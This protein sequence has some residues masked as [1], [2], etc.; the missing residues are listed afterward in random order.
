MEK[1]FLEKWIS[2][3]FDSM[4]MDFSKQRYNNMEEL[5]KYMYGSA[6]VIGYMLCK[7]FDVEE[8]AY[9][10][11]EHLANAMQIGN[12][13]RDIGVDYKLGRTY[14]PQ[15]ILDKYD[16]KEIKKEIDSSTLKKI[17]FEF[18]SFYYKHTKEAR[19]GFK[20]LPYALKIPVATSIQMYDYSVK[21][22]IDN[23]VSVFE[24][25][26][27]PSKYRVILSALINLIKYMFIK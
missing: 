1:Q 19:K 23:P 21:K 3:F 10:F 6:V 4:E 17:I 20:Y 24:I 25:C 18:A 15:N 5:Y 16:V 27:K 11:A 7:I 26:H 14:I 2:A 22:V 13:I 12:F 8:D 9:I